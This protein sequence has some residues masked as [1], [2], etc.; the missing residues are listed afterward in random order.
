MSFCQAIT[1]WGLCGCSFDDTSYAD[2][3][4]SNAPPLRGRNLFDD[5]NIDIQ[6]LKMYLTM[7]LGRLFGITTD[8]ES[9]KHWSL[10]VTMCKTNH[11]SWWRFLTRD[12]F[13][14]FFVT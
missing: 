11:R 4:L 8:A 1:P 9:L 13:Y 5:P 2:V 10:V 3:L 14:Q 12:L 6:F 7:V